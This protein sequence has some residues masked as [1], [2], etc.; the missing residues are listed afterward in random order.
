[1]TRLPS[2]TIFLAI[3]LLF[4]VF[5][6]EAPLPKN[7]ISCPYEIL[8]HGDTEEIVGDHLVPWKTPTANKKRGRF[9]FAAHSY[10]HAAAYGLK[11]KPSRIAGHSV[12]GFR[13][14]YAIIGLSEGRNSFSALLQRNTYIHI[15]SG[16]TFKGETDLQPTDKYPLEWFSREEVK[17][18]DMVFVPNK[19]ILLAGV[20][21]FTATPAT[22]DNMVGFD[23][24]VIR[25]KIRADE[26]TWENH[27]RYK[28]MPSACPDFL[29][30]AFGIDLP[31]RVKRARSRFRITPPRPDA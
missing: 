5:L 12:N 7:E 3:R 18:R 22:V 31:K 26:M 8:F 28:H 6:R 1:L 23:V 29:V 30:H 17:V 27:S 20:Q 10:R 4:C 16:E 25:E 2:S 14:Y 24:R 15:V 19:N 9:V 21:V 11:V 13:F